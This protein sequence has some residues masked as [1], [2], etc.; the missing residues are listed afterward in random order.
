MNT[1]GGAP[2]PRTRAFV[3]FA[4][5]WGVWLWAAC[6]I[7]TI[8]AAWRTVQLYAHLRSEVEALLPRRAPSVLAIDELRARLPGLQ[9]LGV[10]VDAGRAEQLP[11]AERLLDDLAARVRA[12]PRDLV[13]EVRTGNQEERRFLEDH[14][15]LYMEVAD[16]EEIQARV[17]ARRDWE[18]A[19]E[20]GA[21][22]D[23]DAPPPPLD[24]HDLE[25]KYEARATG[26]RRFPRDRFTSAADHTTLLLIEVDR[27]DS[28]R[29]GGEALLDRVKADLAALHPEAYAPGMRVGFTS[30]VAINVEET[31]AL[32]AD[33]SLSS[34]IVIV[35]V[36]AVI[37]LYYE[38]WRSVAVLVPPLLIA[39]IGAFALASLP[40]FRV[41]ELNSNTAFLGSIIVGNGINF[42]IVL[43]ARYV[44]ERRLGVAVQEALV[45]GVWGARTGTLSA[46]LAAAVSYVSLAATDFR[47]FRQFG[48]IGGV[49]ML[50][51]WALTFLL[52]PPLAAWLDRGTPPRPAHRIMPAFVR[53]LHAHQ[54]LVLALAG[55]LAVAAA[56]EVRS[57]GPDQ[58]ETN[59][60]KLRRAD[61]WVNGEGY[62]GRRMDDLLGTYVTP[63]VILTDDAAQAR[64]IGDRLKA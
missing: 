29:S 11:Q 51:S 31:Q 38:W 53:G 40:P 5:K 7:A 58:I 22:L 43:L 44:E 50:L 27:F 10:V 15:P 4:L 35:L 56:W 61:T 54:G 36:V 46:A 13:H 9:H 19:K 21:L 63:T 6:L 57:F 3:S 16:L 62:W 24:F 49:G 1:A 52:V 48:F 47:G 55:A 28:G 33:L 59:F 37:V 60:S 42:G 34:V 18:T 26:G 64:A 32:L 25:Q 23:E 8:P 30:D 41:T 14:A 20:T 17:E 39:S 2:G 12:Y 45:R